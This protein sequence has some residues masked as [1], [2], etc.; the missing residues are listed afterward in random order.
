MASPEYLIQKYEETDHDQ[1][2]ASR[3]EFLRT[4]VG[5]VRI[6][7]RRRRAVRAEPR[8]AG[9]GRR[10]DAPDYKAL[11]CMFLYGG[12]DC[13]EHGAAAPTRPRGTSTRV[14]NQGPTRS[15]CWPPGTPPTT[16]R[17]A[18]SPA[19]LGG[20]LPIT[21]KFTRLDGEQQRA[22]RAASDA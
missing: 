6:G 11:V 15:R 8:D 19:R 10:A 18:A 2:N 13:V 5:R 12:N 4:R 14:R 1:L 21:P 9:R 20:V 17:R 16:A 3:R 22:L 7:R